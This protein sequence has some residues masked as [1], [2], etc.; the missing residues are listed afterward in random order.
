MNAVKKGYEFAIKEPEEAAQLFSK[1][2]PEIDK[3]L[4]LESQK[5]LATK[6]KDDAKYWGMQKQEVWQRYMEW[7][8]EY[9]FIEKE[10]DVAKG[11]TNDFVK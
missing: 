8:L 3:E 11:F 7:L 9:G 4:V 6:Y 5:F 1:A 2:V 10:V